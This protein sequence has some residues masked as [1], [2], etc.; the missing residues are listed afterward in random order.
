MKKL[1]NCPFCGGEAELTEHGSLISIWCKNAGNTERCCNATMLYP[2]EAKCKTDEEI[3][4][5][6][7]KR[8]I[9]AWNT[10][11]EDIDNIAQKICIRY[12]SE[13]VAELWDA[14]ADGKYDSRSIVG[15]TVLDMITELKN[16]GIDAS[17][18]QA[19]EESSKY[20]GEK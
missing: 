12:L 20:Y 17:G 2:A 18:K 5:S 15:D 14:V 1:K 19:L 8:S 11:A 6:I 9:A 13:S 10:R 16:L 4:E 7:T 3:K